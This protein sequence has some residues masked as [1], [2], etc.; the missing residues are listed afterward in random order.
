MSFVPLSGPAVWVPRQPP[1]ESEVEFSGRGRQVRLRVASAIPVLTRAVRADDAHPSVGLLGG[2]TLLAMQLVARGSVRLDD[3]AEAW[4]A[5]PLSSDDDARVRALA[6]ARAHE[7]VPPEEAEDLVR[8]LLDA[9]AD[10]MLRSPGAVAQPRRQVVR[11]RPPAEVAP[12]H[13]DLPEQV[14]LVVRVEAPEE[15]L[16]GGGV[17]VALQAHALDDETHFVD[18]ERLWVDPP[19]V[20]RFHPRARVAAGVA[21]REAATAWTPLDRLQRQQVPDRMVL[22]ADE[23]ADLLEHGVEA[24]DA[25]GVDVLWPRSLRAELVPQGRVEVRQGTRETPL[26]DSLLAPDA[27]FGF[28]WR[29]ALRDASGDLPLTDEEMHALAAATTPVVRLRDHWWVVD[30]AV[31]RRARK[32]VRAGLDQPEREVGAGTAL[33]AALTGSLEVD[34]A[35]VEVHPGATLERVRERIVDAAQVAPL[36]D[37]PGLRATLRDYQRRGLTW[38][39]ELTGVGVGACLADDMGLGKTVTL[40]ALHL[41]RRSRGLLGGPTLVVCPASLLG[42]WEGELRRFA[43]DVAVRRFHGSSRSL[44]DLD[45]GF[46]LT[47]YGTM[48][49]DAAGAAALAGVTWD[50]VVA[51]EAQHVKNP[52]SATARHLRALRSRC[53]VALT[54][55]PVENNL[56]DLWAILDWATPGLLGSRAAFRK[57]WAAPIEA[58]VDPAVARRFAQLVGPFLLRRRKSDPGIAPELPAK[59]E[60]DHVVGLTQEQVVL[61]ETL[62]R[63]S[64]RRIREADEETRRGLVLALLTGLKQICN[65]PAHYLRQPSGRLRG[66]SGKLELFDELLATVLADDG[67]DGSA[68]LVFTQYVE[69]ARLLERHLA[70]AGVPTMLLHGGTPVRERERMVRDFQAGT[71][72]VFLLSLKA[73]GTGLTLTRADHVVHLDRWWNPAVEDQA[74]DRAHRIGQTRAVQ[75]HRLMTEGTI[76]ERIG[77][78]LERKRSVAAAVLGGSEVALTEL[79]D[80][81]LDDLVHLRRTGDLPDA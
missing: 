53:R 59:T 11:H 75:V 58:G 46:V 49:S 51:D 18:V 4:R 47:T 6:V 62:V 54:G 28:D 23:L 27:L 35:T 70:A 50:L 7:E 15:V 80:D 3:D 16:V 52:R 67:P 43:P 44:A 74:T 24:L 78:L 45:D 30:P 22:D 31:A 61:Y 81:E 73:G 48:R 60:T 40:I 72:P 66:R 37:P 34:G 32:R 64:M 36:A 9:V 17:A 19:D 13:A 41:H 76:E 63:E 77:R 55:T 56:V 39:A 14:R 69:M 65:H 42:T 33:Q 10:S 25:V 21:L 12:E 20:H 38:L 26:Q 71:V 29:L 79:S 68:M 57:A 8:E 5:G 1:R 2:A